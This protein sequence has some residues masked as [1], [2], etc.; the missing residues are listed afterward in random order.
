MG[1]LISVLSF[2][3]KH[4][5]IITVVIIG[6]FI[7]IPVLSVIR[8]RDS[9]ETELL[10]AA[11]QVQTLEAQVLGFKDVAEAD[12]LQIAQLVKERSRTSATLE[13]YSSEL[14]ALRKQSEHMRSQLQSLEENDQTVKA[15]NN[16]RIP[17]QLV[18][19]LNPSQYSGSSICNE[20]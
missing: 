1:W 10:R 5:K 8:E 17:I 19:L 13:Q 7:A 2:L 4:S 16:T 12:K 9:L 14:K 6:A 11:S 18:C 20:D 3:A 15:Y